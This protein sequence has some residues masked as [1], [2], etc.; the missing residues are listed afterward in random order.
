MLREETFERVKHNQDLRKALTPYLTDETDPYFDTFLAAVCYYLPQ[1]QLENIF[2]E[3]AYRNNLPEFMKK[4]TICEIGKGPHSR[5]FRLFGKN[6]LAVTEPEVN[7][8]PTA[9][10][11]S[12]YEGALREERVVDLRFFAEHS[13]SGQEFDITLS[14][15]FLGDITGTGLVAGKPSKRHME[16]CRNEQYKLFHTLSSIRNM[17]AVFSNI[18]GMGGISIHRCD[19]SFMK[20]LDQE[21]YIQLLG[22]HMEAL[23]EPTF[24]GGFIKDEA[25]AALKKTHGPKDGIH[26][27]FVGASEIL[28]IYNGKCGIKEVPDKFS[29]A[30]PSHIGSSSSALS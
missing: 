7:P 25:I 26:P 16:L 27:F 5:A 15:G 17:L 19:R 4:A 2:D 20:N 24:K 1:K 3:T 9:R 21:N 18:T 30:E 10:S 28:H 23:L 6:Y 29:N 14:H 12:H 8:L 11:V 22:F 13:L